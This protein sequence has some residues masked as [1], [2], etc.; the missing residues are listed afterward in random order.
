MIIN[1]TGKK[2]DDHLSLVQDWYRN[3]EQNIQRKKKKALQFKNI[4]VGFKSLTG[5]QEDK[6]EEI[7]QN[8]KQNVKELEGKVI[9]RKVQGVLENREVIW[10]ISAELTTISGKTECLAQ[11]MEIDLYTV[12]FLNAVGKKDLTS[13]GERG[14][15]KTWTT[16]KVC[17][18]YVTKNSC[19]K[20]QESE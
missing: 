3:K 13:Y 19:I 18:E 4:T 11:W 12:S 15:K 2:R 20:D 5:D 9:S 7:S 16:V 14:K 10:E 17:I 8:E 6:I 1:T